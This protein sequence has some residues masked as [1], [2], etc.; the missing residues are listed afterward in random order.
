MTEF[1]RGGSA[2]SFERLQ[3]F[4]E[5]VE[6]L[7]RRQERQAILDA[8]AQLRPT[9]NSAE[10]NAAFDEA[11]SAAIRVVVERSNTD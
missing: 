9:G 10:S 5:T 2:V 8:L 11:I 7:A 3:S 6:D 4:V 1:K